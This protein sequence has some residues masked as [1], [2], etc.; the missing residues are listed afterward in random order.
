MMQ[1]WLKKILAWLKKKW[2]LVAIVILAIIAA[3]WFTQQQQKQKETE[4]AD[5][6]TITFTNQDLTS[7]LNLS[8]IVDAKRKV[9]LFYPTGGKLTRL[10]VKK[11]DS[12]KAGQVLAV[13]DQADLQKRLE[14]SLNTYMVDRLE[15]DYDQDKLKDTAYTQENALKT[16]REQLLLNNTVLDVEIASIAINN[17]RLTCPIDG[18]LI[19]APDLVAPMN[20]LYTDV[21]TVVD[22]KSL[23]FRALVDEL[24]LH[25]IHEGQKAIIKIDALPD[26]EIIA[27]INNISLTSTSGSSGT[28]F[29]IEFLLP[30]FDLN[31]VR[32]GMN[33]D[34]QVIL[35]E[36][37]Q[38]GSVPLEAI[39]TKEGQSY[40]RIVDAQ[41]NIVERKVTLGLETDNDVEIVEGLTLGETVIV[42]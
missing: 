27:N 30:N 33:G 21:F 26:E 38:V 23:I 31:T 13:I 36:K 42:N 19:Q 24:D 17:A 11:G 41:K 18:I 22:P 14:R 40:V 1:N 20:V 28:A 9:N 34:A 32:L 39:F 3:T 25:L 12:V 15:F 10:N 37:T 4:L 29:E 7:T 35:A 5:L 16:N 2:W 6:E 8:G